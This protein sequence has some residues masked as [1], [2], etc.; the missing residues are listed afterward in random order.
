MEY[1]RKSP[2]KGPPGAEA[3]ASSQQ[4]P[5]YLYPEGDNVF[6]ERVQVYKRVE[7]HRDPNRWR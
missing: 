3:G 6:W 4:S 1:K 7:F 2:Q 5:L